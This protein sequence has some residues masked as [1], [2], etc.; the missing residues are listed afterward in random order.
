[1]LILHDSYSSD[2]SH[3]QAI[4]GMEEGFGLFDYVRIQQRDGKTWIGQIV[5]PNQNISVVGDRLDST[6]LHG[7]QLAQ[8]YENIQS[9]ESVQVFDIL[10]LGQYD[11]KRMMTPRIRPLPGA[12]VTKLTAT[13]TMSVIEIP[14]LTLYADGSNNVIGDLLNAEAVPLCIRADL[15]NYHFLV[16]GGTGAGKSNV[17]ANLIVQ[18]VRC[19]KCVLVHDA[20]PDYRLL[21]QPNKDP[22]VAEVWQQFEQYGLAPAALTDIVRIGFY[23]RCRPENVDRV[24]GFR[25]SDFEPEMLAGMLFTEAAE[26]NQFEGFILAAQ[27]LRRQVE[28]PTHSRSGY[29]L[30]DILQEVGLR[31]D[32]RG[33]VEP[34]E[35]IHELTGRA[36][37]RKARTRS[38]AMPWLDSVGQPTGQNVNRLRRST[39]NPASSPTVEGFDLAGYVKPGRVIVIDYAQMDDPSYALLLSYFLRVCQQYRRNRIGAGMVQLVDEAHRVFNNDSRHSGILG[40]AFERVMRE[41]R[42]VDH[43]IILGLQNASQVPPRVMNNLN[44]KIVM[45]QNSKQEADAAT[46]TMGREFGVQA[47]T[48]G[49]GQ[50]LVSLFESRA[51]V[52]AQMAPS[53]FELMRNDNARSG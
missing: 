16:A 11:G 13:D 32:P 42:S 21:S 26:Q 12:V 37:L 35:M 5:Q 10:I 39:L 36:I 6:V 20:K 47:M 29:S 18:A 33:L 24:V 14:P 25:A 48:L 22:K 45:H 41:G 9:V 52:L 46:Q 44:S 27:N 7:L 49:T 31:S 43:S 50:A 19:G 53:P 17:A 38:T 51:T 40:R 34:N 30:E 3:V 1:M 28:D 4:A 15:F 8:S 2:L 23:D